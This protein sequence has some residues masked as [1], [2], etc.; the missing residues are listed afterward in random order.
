MIVAKGIY[1]EDNSVVALWVLPL[2][3]IPIADL[4]SRDQ[5]LG[6]LKCI[7]I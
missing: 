1:K 4:Y 6:L 2:G 5:L 3:A 7:Y